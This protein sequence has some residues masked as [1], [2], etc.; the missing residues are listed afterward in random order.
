MK[1]ITL[2]I[3]NVPEETRRD[4]K[5]LAAKEGKPMQRIVLDLIKNKIKDT[6]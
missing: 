1:L 3:R 4:L 5:A 6:K 2:I